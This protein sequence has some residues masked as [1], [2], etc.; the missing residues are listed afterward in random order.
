[1]A[2]TSKPAVRVSAK[3]GLNLKTTEALAF[4][5]EAL[6]GA[7]QE[8]FEIDIV[9]TAKELSPILDEATK[10]R[11]PGENRDSIDARVTK[12]K[13]GVRARVFTTSGY[14]GFLELGTVK[15][16]AQPYIFPAFQQN[17]GNLAALVKENILTLSPKEKARG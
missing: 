17:I 5:N 13:K 6:Y 4:V 12:V 15:T 1:M 9:T 2:K 7:M 14:G 10:E 8:K 16:Q 3:V 11:Y